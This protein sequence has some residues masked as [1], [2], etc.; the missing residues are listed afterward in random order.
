MPPDYN[1]LNNITII[2]I[3]QEYSF[4]HVQQEND[5][6]DNESSFFK[7]FKKIVKE[8][9]SLVDKAAKAHQAAVNNEKIRRNSDTESLAEKVNEKV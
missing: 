3:I 1:K 5:V 7:T 9:E 8:V 2:K 6:Q 4:N